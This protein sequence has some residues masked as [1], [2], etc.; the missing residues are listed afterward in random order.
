MRKV[1]REKETKQVVVELSEW[2][3]PATAVGATGIL[4]E[5]EIKAHVE[6]AAWNCY[7]PR[8]LLG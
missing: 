8:Q 2:F 5:L 6:T 3:R 7:Q 1:R 4:L